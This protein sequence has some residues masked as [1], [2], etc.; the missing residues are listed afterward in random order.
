MPKTLMWMALI[1]AGGILIWL[2]ALEVINGPPG[3]A[4]K[5]QSEDLTRDLKWIE[6]KKS[7]LSEGKTS[8]VQF[9]CTTNTDILI[10]YLA[11]MREVK[12]L[13]F[14]MTDLSS[15]GLKVVANLPEIEELV[16]YGSVS[17]EPKDFKEHL[18]ILSRNTKLSTLRLISLKLTDE[19]ISVLPMF[20]RLENVTLYQE[21]VSDRA[22]ASL[23]NCSHL[24]RLT[25][26]SGMASIVAVAALKKKL[27][28]CEIREQVDIDD[29]EW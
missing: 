28:E 27:P 13:S 18:M 8:K 17:N 2:C 5:R 19:A 14:Q 23:E 12:K 7:L 26:R 6:T 11:G 1:A 20:Q 4:A 25:I 15:V 22:I 21:S 10:R 3:A 9:Y 16:L 29:D 24:K